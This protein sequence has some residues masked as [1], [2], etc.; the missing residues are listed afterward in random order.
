MHIKISVFTSVF[1]LSGL[2][3]C[4]SISPSKTLPQSE[5]A[6]SSVNHTNYRSYVAADVDAVQTKLQRANDAAI[7]KEHQTA[8]QLAQQILVDVELIKI[9]A[10]RISAE[11]KVTSLEASITNLHQELQWREPIRLSPLDP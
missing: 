10:Q 9:K 6:V 11:Q 4:T 1:L 5:V 2:L 8:E 3:G 7:N